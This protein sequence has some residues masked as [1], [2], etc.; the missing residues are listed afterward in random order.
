MQFHKEFYHKLPVLLTHIKSTS[1]IFDPNLNFDMLHCLCHK[2]FKVVLVV[3][4]LGIFDRLCVV[5]FNASRLINRTYFFFFTDYKNLS[6][7]HQ[8]HHMSHDYNKLLANHTA[9][10]RIY[11]RSLI[12]RYVQKKIFQKVAWVQSH[13]LQ[14]KVKIHILGGK[15]CLSFKDK[16]LLDIVSKLLK[17]KSLLTS[18]SNVLPYY[19]K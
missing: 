11:Y 14:L 5:N 8:I 18:P 15:V 13:H 16:T 2:R 3:K 4:F 12:S 9:M 17:T 6:S 7:N 1:I 10:E 19:L